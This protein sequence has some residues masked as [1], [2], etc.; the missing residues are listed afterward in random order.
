LVTHTE[1]E[2]RLR[3]FKSGVLRKIF[4]PERDEVTGDWGRLH[5]ELFNAPYSSSN[6]IRMIKLRKMRWKGSVACMGERRSANRIFAGK[7]EEK[8]PLE[9]PSPRRKENIKKDFQEAEYL[10]GL[11]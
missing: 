6:I 2:S 11:D 1:E 5:N 7:P 3:V 8:R 10:N 9:R 4:G